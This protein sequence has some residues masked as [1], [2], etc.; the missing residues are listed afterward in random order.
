MQETSPEAQTS[1]YCCCLRHCIFLLTMALCQ[2]L[3]KTLQCVR[4]LTLH[5]TYLL[6]KHQG[7]SIFLLKTPEQLSCYQCCAVSEPLRF[8]PHQFYKLRWINE[9][10]GITPFS[11]IS[12]SEYAFLLH[13]FGVYCH[14]Y[15]PSKKNTSICQRAEIPFK[16]VK[17][18]LLKILYPPN[19]FSF[20]S[21]R[22]QSSS[23]VRIRKIGNLKN[24]ELH[25]Y[26][27]RHETSMYLLIY[28][29]YL[30]ISHKEEL[31]WMR[32]SC[33]NSQRE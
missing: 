27:T 17:N 24:P 26:F 22:L 15:F 7:I 3:I 8:L 18:R 21:W 20:F 31:D 14:V 11:S 10:V 1:S 28:Q 30:L 5:C 33:D 29:Y 12:K 23:D 32:G 25:F 4:E 13:S 2:A 6:Q 9:V 16:N 19:S